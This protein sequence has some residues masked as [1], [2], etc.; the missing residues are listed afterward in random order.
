MKVP[1]F[2]LV[3]AA[4][5]FKKKSFRKHFEVDEHW[6]WFHR[7]ISRLLE[8]PTIEITRL[9]QQMIESELR[10]MGEI[11]AA[12]WYRDYWTGEHGNVTNATAGYVGNNTSA[13]LEAHW[14]YMRRDTIGSAGS[15]MRVAVS[16]FISLLVKYVRDTSEKHADKVLN[17]KTGKHMFQSAPIITAKVWNNVQ[18]F[19][20]VRLVLSRIEGAE[21]PAGKWK[22]EVLKFFSMVR[23]PMYDGRDR[24][25]VELM[26]EFRDNGNTIGLARR[27]VIAVLMPDP[28][29]VQHLM[30]KYHVGKDTL[31][32]LQK[33]DEML[34]PLRDQYTELF[35]RPGEWIRTHKDLDVEYVLDVMES[36]VR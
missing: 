6:E 17:Q 13:G 27:D 21:T 7:V 5:A 29:L 25:I 19:D 34:Q 10:I 3:F 32:D 24:S 26:Q 14:R 22:Q 28:L 2:I 11:K 15:N 4:I 1:D 16:T 9:I 12:N 23:D 18:K 35:N 33:L 30:R 20:I 8:A 31:E 36:F